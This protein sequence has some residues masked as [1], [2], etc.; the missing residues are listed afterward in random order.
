MPEQI[1]YYALFLKNY[2]NYFNRIIKGFY[3]ADDYIDAVGEGNYFL[4]S[5]AINYNPADNV[6]TELIM[7]DCPFDPDYLLILDKDDEIVAR[8]FVMESM[9]TREKQ[10]KFILR[11]DVV[12]DNL[13]DLLDSPAY[14][15]KA[16]LQDNDPFI[17]NDEGMSFN[18]IKTSE[19]LLKDKTNSAWIIGYIAKNVAPTDITI[20]V[21]TDTFVGTSL[22]TI[23]YDMGISE[24]SLAALINFDGTNTN[25]ALFTKQIEFRFGISFSSIRLKKVQMFYNGDLDLSQIAQTDAL[26]W[27][28]VLWTE[29]ATTGM[30]R[31]INALANKFYSQKSS[32]MAQMDTITSRTYMSSSQLEKLKKYSN[33]IISY[34]GNYYKMRILESAVQNDPVIGPSVYTSWT[35]ISSAVNA[36]ALEVSGYGNINNTGEMSIRTKSTVAFIQFDLVSDVSGVL[37]GAS[38][39]ISSNRNVVRNQAFDMFAI[40]AGPALINSQFYADKDMS[41]LVATKIAEELTVSL[42]DLQLLPYCPLPNLIQ[43]SGNID[44]TGKTEGKD[45]DWILATNQSI[46]V[47]IAE[48]QELTPQWDNDAQEWIFLYEETVEVDYDIISNSGWDFA[49]PETGTG[50]PI[51]TLTKIDATHTK[52]SWRA[53]L[54]TLQT[55]DSIWINVWYEYI[56]NVAKSVILWAKD[57]SF[58]HI[59]NYSLDMQD[60]IKVE[61]LCNKYRIVSPNYQGSFD[62]N[63]AKNGGTVDYFV[64]E[65]SYKPY[66][67]YIKVAPAFNYFYGTNFGDSRGLICGGDFSM[68]RFT[69]AWE[70]F[71]LNNKNY[72]N[73]FNRDIQN[74]D[75]EQNLAYRQQL[76]T[77]GIGVFTGGV[78]GAGIGAKVGGVYGAIAGAVAGTAGSGAGM[79][80]DTAM[81]TDKQREAKQY[82]ID[83]YNYQL[84]N[85]KALPYTLTKVGAFDINSKIFPFVEYYT[86]TPE[87]KDA[88]RNK[89]TF[90]SM[91]VM[92][93]GT[94]REYLQ[95]ERHYF[96]A[97]LIRN[98]KIAED[99][100]IFEAIYSEL[101]KGVF[102]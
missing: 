21:P 12:F 14:V 5:K 6:S 99:N 64:A 42:Y 33:D 80:L 69:S 93:I 16:M 62:F 7:N 46:R 26:S 96:K 77:G 82:A 57:N 29:T 37:P 27:A 66:T 75:F 88:L 65:C 84:G 73:I 91:T 31:F 41:L 74:L 44:L 55:Q 102:I 20:S 28:H 39:K 11:R 25:Q 17:F 47:Y 94:L 81:M 97:E 49:V 9:F 92:R 2:N 60:E 98:E 95:D 68:P 63:V 58:S 100:H 19:T 34:N 43:N 76:I 15:Q 22:S 87:E 23:A 32:I 85:I 40:P 79:A 83:K 72:Q 53:P 101:L 8:W 89:I 35:S 86:C 52:F 30:S 4:Y 90:E 59:L 18:Q 1:A 61:S 36:A 13:D 71:E 38:T 70:T 67:P 24:A 48:N 54:G 56:S 10:R 3:T 50:T 78:A 45:F 51:L